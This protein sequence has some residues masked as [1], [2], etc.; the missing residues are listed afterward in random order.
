MSSNIL[1]IFNPPKPS[2]N[3]N[4]GSGGSSSNNGNNNNPEEPCLQC[5]TVSSAV[6]I[7]AGS[8]L[9]S[10]LVFYTKDNKPLPN[11]TPTWKMTVRGAGA[12]VLGLGLYRGISALQLALTGDTPAGTLKAVS[13]DKKE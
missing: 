4:A 2:S 12:F 7:G 10:G 3:S 11:V 9:A 8:Y 13:D 6:M 5:L 1:D